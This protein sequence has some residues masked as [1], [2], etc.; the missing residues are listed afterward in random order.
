MTRR[1]PP[2]SALRAFEAVARL[3][4]VT[5]AGEELGRTHSAVSRQIGAL[6]DHAGVAL[7]DKAGTGLRLNDTGAAF[8][9][10]VAAALDA[11][12]QGWTRV[13]DDAR[14]SGLHI[15]CSA[16]FAMRWL[17]PHLPGFYRQH[18]ELKLRL[19]MTTAQEIRHQDADLVI[20]WDRRAW[21]QQDRDRAIPLAGIAFGPVCAPSYPVTATHRSLRCAQRITHEYTTQAW[22]LWEAGSGQRIAYDSEL[23]FPHTHLC[24]EAAVSGLGVALVE[25][26]MVRDDI[27]GGRLVAPCG[28]TDFTEGLAAIP[29][30]ARATTPAARAFLSWITAEL[31]AED[32]IRLPRAH[33]SPHR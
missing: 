13:L 19:S 6:Q 31:G 3:G 24:L 27:A 10:V 29:G 12:E 7:F 4:S 8:R 16:T 20:A 1:L 5:R 9:Q 26:R 30:F 2:L 23:Q 14:G 15:A 33:A 28:F 11:L 21:P 18:P 22:A 17:V 25:R 32:A